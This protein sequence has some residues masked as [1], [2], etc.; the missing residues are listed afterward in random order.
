MPAECDGEIG[1][2]G[3]LANQARGRRLQQRLPGGDI[4]GQAGDGLQLAG[5]KSCAG[6]LRL[7]GKLR[8]VEQAAEGD[9]YLLGEEQAHLGGQLRAGGRSMLRRSKGGARESLR[10]RPATR[11][12]LPRAPAAAPTQGRQSRHS[13][14][15]TEWDRAAAYPATILAVAEAAQSAGGTSSYDVEPGVVELGAGFVA[16]AEAG[17]DEAPEEVSPDFAGAIWCRR[18]LAALPLI[19]ADSEERIRTLGGVVVHVPAGALELRRGA[20]SGRSRTPWHL[21]HSVSGS[22][23]EVLYL[24]KFDGRTGCSDIHTRARRFNS[25]GEFNALF[26][27]YRQG[28]NS[29]QFTP[30]RR[31]RFFYA[32]SQCTAMRTDAEWF[33]HSR[34]ILPVVPPRS[35]DGVFQIL[36]HRG[37]LL[38]FIFTLPRSFEPS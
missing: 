28:G 34:V 22:A 2:P 37:G 35:V 5:L 23:D 21:G 25:P 7:C 15:A 38:I 3:E 10:G 1:E 33:S 14:P 16:G 26:P 11:Q 13:G 36:D 31:C 18:K 32:G 6:N 17:A 29:L 27:L 19:G 8:G 4:V 12:S 20:V 30:P 9:R 24:F